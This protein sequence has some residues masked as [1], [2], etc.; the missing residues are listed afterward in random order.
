MSG[1]PP[2]Q[3][4]HEIQGAV[5][6]NAQIAKKGSIVSPGDILTTGSGSSAVIVIGGDAHLIRENSRIIIGKNVLAGQNVFQIIAGKILSVYSKGDKKIITPTATIGIRG[7]GLYI[8]VEEEMTYVCLCYG[9]AEIFSGNLSKPLEKIQTT[10]HEA[11]RYIYASGSEKI[12]E[13]PVKNHTD[14]ELTFLESLV[15]RVPPFAAKKG[16]SP[17]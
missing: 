13:A 10:H 16:A 5:R 9:Q 6:I 12:H 11:P 8:E 7:T 14:D 1:R 4:V 17:Y 2:V 15:G 3:G